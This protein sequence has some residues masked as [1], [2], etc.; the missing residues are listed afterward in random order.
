MLNFALM[1]HW[2][3]WVTILLMV[4]I[5]SFAVHSLHKLASASVVEK[6]S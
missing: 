3:N 5:A 6:E 1:K 4:M 2:E